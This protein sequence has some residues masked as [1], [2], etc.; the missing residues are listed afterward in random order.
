[1]LVHGA[2]G[3]QVFLVMIVVVLMIEVAD[4]Y[5]GVILVLNP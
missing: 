2:L 1:M 4:C 5:E 3:L